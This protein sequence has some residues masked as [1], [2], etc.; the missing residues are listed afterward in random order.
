MT[1]FFKTFSGF[2]LIILFCS[3]SAFGGEFET[4]LEKAERGDK[5]A[6]NYLALMYIKG[7][8]V[9]RDVHQA[10]AWFKKAAD[11]GHV[12]AANSLGLLYYRGKGVAKNYSKAAQWFTKAA[13]KGYTDAQYNLGLMY[14]LGR[15]DPFDGSGVDKDYAKALKWFKKAARQGHASAHNNIGIMYFNGHGVK[16][17]LKKSYVWNYKAIA[18]GNRNALSFRKKLLKKIPS[19]QLAEAKEEIA[20]LKEKESPEPDE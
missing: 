17:D 7:Q 12:S 3:L 13:E 16:Q 2:A 11:G 19:Q 10:I 1:Y 14:Y 6:Q 9:D 5:N 4:V 15:K 18:L 8:G 20:K